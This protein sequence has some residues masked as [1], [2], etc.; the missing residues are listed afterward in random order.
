MFAESALKRQSINPGFRGSTDLNCGALL[1]V[2][3]IYIDINDDDNLR[4][5]EFFGLK[6]EDCPTLRLILLEEDLVKYRPPMLDL[7]AAGIKKFVQ[8]YLDGKL[9]VSIAQILLGSSHVELVVSSH[10]VRQAR[11]SQNT[12]TQRV[13]LVET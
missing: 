4:V 10:A 9:K 13:E 6:P 5:L 1:Q 8:D 2:L 3:F 7:T 12:W 11:P